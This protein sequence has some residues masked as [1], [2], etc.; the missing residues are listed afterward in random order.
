MSCFGTNSAVCG[1]G[2]AAV[3]LV[4]KLEARAG[5]SKVVAR[6]TTDSEGRFQ[7]DVPSGAGGL[8]VDAPPYPSKFA[9]VY[10]TPNSEAVSVIEASPE[11]SRKGAWSTSPARRSPERW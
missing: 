5:E 11:C 6:E 2:E 1:C 4:D 10:F 9:R 7:V 8:W 3:T